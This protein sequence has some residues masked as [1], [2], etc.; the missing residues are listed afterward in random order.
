MNWRHPQSLAWILAALAI[1]LIYAIRSRKCVQD[2]ATLFLWKRA[3]EHRPPWIRIRPWVAAVCRALIV[4]FLALA[5]AMPTIGPTQIAKRSFVFVLDG[6][7]SM[8]ATD[9]T[10]TRFDQARTEILELVKNLGESDRAAL[11]VVGV[12]PY[13]AQR[14]TDDFAAFNA[15]VESARVCDAAGDIRRGIAMAKGLAGAADASRVLV[16][17]DAA[18]GSEGNKEAE[19]RVL[20]G[21]ARNVGIT[22]IATRPATTTESDR[23]EVVVVLQSFGDDGES[24]VPVRWR[25][26]GGSSEDDEAVLVDGV[27]VVRREFGFGSLIEVAVVAED[28]LAIDNQAQLALDFHPAYFG[29]A[30]SKQIRF[31]YSTSA[32]VR[33]AS[34]VDEIRAPDDSVRA[35]SD[36]EV[37]F[38]PL[39]RQGAW[40]VI[41]PNGTVRTW[42]AYLGSATESNIASSKNEAA[43]NGKIG[44][45]PA[46]LPAKP[47][48]IWF[49]AIAALLWAAETVACAIGGTE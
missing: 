27:A 7:A 2:T 3:L 12:E 44:I 40:R 47:I 26:E 35:V 13:V 34:G 45:E 38:G 37:I 23:G 22:S 10:P 11:I 33:F 28:H 24:T 41:E 5:L 8:Q 20:A 17:T 19:I 25:T 16:F 4:V 14:F 18:V 39:D 36:G 43:D 9:V 29:L 42:H 32:N 46:R 1:F 30:E 21:D 49:L 31:G 15:A 48:H 6:T